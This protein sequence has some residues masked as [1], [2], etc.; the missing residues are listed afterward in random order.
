MRPFSAVIIA[1]LVTPLSL[2]AEPAP[3]CVDLFIM[4]VRDQLNLTVAKGEAFLTEGQYAKVVDIITNVLKMDPSNPKAHI[5]REKLMATIKAEEIKKL[6]T[7]GN[8]DKALKAA[9]EGLEALPENLSLNIWKLKIL[10]RMKNYTE[11]L[12]L[13]QAILLKNASS[14]AALEVETYALMQLKRYEEA[15]VVSEELIFN[16]DVTAQN[17]RIHAELLARTKQYTDS[18]DAV[19]A[20]LKVDPSDS[21][22]LLLKSFLLNKLNRYEEAILIALKTPAKERRSFILATAYLRVEKYREAR[23]YIENIKDL[24]SSRML[25][26]EYYFK[27][28]NLAKAW[29]LLHLIVDGA[30]KPNLFAIAALVKIENYAGDVQDHPYLDKLEKTLATSVFRQVVTFSTRLDWSLQDKS[31]N[32]DWVPSIQ[33]TFWDRLNSIPVNSWTARTTR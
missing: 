27:T 7:A 20:A 23:P 3:R 25:Q 28:G 30:E 8:Y 16:G 29:E 17:Y 2:F 32:D 18:M 26:A 1:V 9:N 24:P 15:L 5:L 22:A 4:T 6:Y 14:R 19:E 11:A 13:S 31:S 12:A 33:N 10:T 21:Q